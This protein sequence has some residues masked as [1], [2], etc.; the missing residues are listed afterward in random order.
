MGPILQVSGLRK[1]FY[2]L[3]VLCGV[4]LEV[5]PQE[6]VGLIGP[7]GSGKTTLFNCI[8][9]LYKL[10]AGHVVYNGIDI[11]GQ[12]PHKV[13]LAGLTRSFQMVQ[14]YAGLTVLQNLLIALQE[15]Q[16]RNQIARVLRLA[17]VRRAEEASRARAEQILADFGL[18][19]FRDTEAGA[20]SYGQKKLVEFA[21]VLMPD[22]ILIML[23]EP[24]AAVN[25]TMINQMK[26]H[27]RRLHAAGKAFLLI[28]HNMN[29]V[30][31]ICQRVVVLDHGEKIAEGTP[32]FVRRH[33]RVLEAYFGR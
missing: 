19:R 14:V 25:P 17:R 23:D 1:R 33:D 27:I 15:H 26:A 13:A 11:T 9:G 18:L 30:M 5:R 21:A 2:G 16:E 31:D 7:N 10:D 22:P 32:D 29:V 6:V 28:E 20:L 24:A 8:T 3:E 12:K 4:D